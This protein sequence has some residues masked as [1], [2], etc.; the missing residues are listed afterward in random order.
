MR[1]KQGTDFISLLYAKV[2]KCWYT[3]FK[4]S[5]RK[6]QEVSIENKIFCH[7]KQKNILGDFCY[8]FSI[9][10]LAA[11][12]NRKSNVTPNSAGAVIK[13]P[14]MFSRET[15][16]TSVSKWWQDT[17]FLFLLVCFVFFFLQV[18]LRLTRNVRIQHQ[19]HHRPTLE[20]DH[21]FCKRQKFTLLDEFIYPGN[22][23]VLEIAAALLFISVTNSCRLWGSSCWKSSTFPTGQFM[24]VS[25]AR[26]AGLLWPHSFNP[27][28]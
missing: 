18:F 7:Q 28:T 21:C 15:K 22:S 20:V 12:V 10:L 11:Q 13:V 2:N 14:C 8:K 25:Y 19:D 6:F 17:G 1:T 5:R 4:K 23:I 26:D 3:V 9:V 27:V 24:F 16:D